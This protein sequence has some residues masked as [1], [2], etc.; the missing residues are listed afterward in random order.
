MG[1]VLMVTVENTE[2]PG[3][4]SHL[5]ELN[6]F[7]EEFKDD[8]WLKEI[9][10]GE[11][12]C[13]VGSPMDLGSPCSQHT[14]L[15]REDIENAAMSFTIYRV[16]LAVY[17]VAQAL[18]DIQRCV[19]SQGLLAN[20]KCPSLRHVQPWQ[21]MKYLMSVNFTAGSNSGRHVSFN[22]DGGI[23]DTFNIIQWQR[24]EKMDKSDCQV[25]NFVEIGRHKDGVLFINESLSRWYDDL[26]N[27]NTVSVIFPLGTKQRRLK[28]V[29]RVDWKMLTGKN[30]VARIE[31]YKQLYIVIESDTFCIPPIILL[32]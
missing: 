28:A 30:I 24:C 18:V 27:L 32:H 22:K 25:V 13:K 23:M 14:L 4:Q 21:L 29:V 8:P 26:T 16:Y 5:R 20:G 17:A 15:E 12:G 2:I 1:N 31:I 10:E 9:W 3:F 6:P 7:L 11:F 19:E